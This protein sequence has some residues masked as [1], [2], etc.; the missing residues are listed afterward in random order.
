MATRSPPVAASAVDDLVVYWRTA[1]RAAREA[2][3]AAES[4]PLDERHERTRRLTAEVASTQ[5]LLQALERDVHGRNHVLPLVVSPVEA[6]RLLGLPP[7]ITAC[8]FNLDGVLIGSATL[9]AEAWTETFDEFIS[10]R[11][12]RTGGQFL[13]FNPR[14]DYPQHMHGRA[15]LD[16]VR[17]FLASRGIRLPEGDPSDPPG[18]ETVQGLANRKSQVLVRSLE[19]HGVHAFD[20][21]RSFLDLAHEAGLRCA[22]VSAS[23]NTEAILERARLAD[24]VDERVDGTTIRREHLQVKPAPDTLLAACQRLGVEPSHTAAFETTRAGVAAGRSAGFDLIVGVDGA[25]GADRGDALR[26]E[27]ADI[28]VGG[29]GELLERRLAA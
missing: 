23:S 28:V 12:E 5:A 4:L 27:G 7:E 18:A 15:R 16:G 10:A 11:V 22:V 17:G 21:S 29:I 24:L 1:L 9:H 20:G 25:T 6:R 13:P 26:A 19:E 3:A 8:V 14:I 2:L